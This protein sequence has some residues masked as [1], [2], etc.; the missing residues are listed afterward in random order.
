[1]SARSAAGRRP[2]PG[3]GGNQGLRALG[4]SAGHGFVRG[5]S[6]TLGT[7]VVTAIIWWVQQ[8]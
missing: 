4:R 2:W 7:F 8:R 3:A 6:G 5:A 1:M